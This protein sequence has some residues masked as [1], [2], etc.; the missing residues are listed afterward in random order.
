MVLHNVM[1]LPDYRD[2]GFAVSAVQAAVNWCHKNPDHGPDEGSGY[3]LGI[4]QL[5][6][7]TLRE[8]NLQNFFRQFGFVKVD[9]TRLA[10]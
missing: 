1:C 9:Y 3:E 4:E 7:H 6:L 5:I 2:R 8:G 10:S